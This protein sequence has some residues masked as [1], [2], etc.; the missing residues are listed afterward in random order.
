MLITVFGVLLHPLQVLLVAFEAPG[1]VLDLR[2]HGAL[3][4]AVVQNLSLLKVLTV[5]TAEREGER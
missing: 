2:H 5:V 4:K 1:V 3:F